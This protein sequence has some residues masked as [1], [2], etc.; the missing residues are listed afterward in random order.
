[1]AQPSPIRSTFSFG[2]DS[3]LGVPCRMP[4]SQIHSHRIQKLVQKLYV[5]LCNSS[6]FFIT[7][8]ATP[9]GLLYPNVISTFKNVLCIYIGSNS[10]IYIGNFLAV[11]DGIISTRWLFYFQMWY[12]G[13]GVFCPSAVLIS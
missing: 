10:I 8:R 9:P 2:G 7:F 11:T 13:E 5:C 6:H 3:C 12:T 4:K 1:M